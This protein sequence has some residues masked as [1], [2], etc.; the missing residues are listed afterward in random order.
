M[1]Q[2]VAENRKKC[3]KYKKD[4]KMIQKTQ[5]ETFWIIF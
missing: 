1:A 3:K 4:Q 5:K 2:K